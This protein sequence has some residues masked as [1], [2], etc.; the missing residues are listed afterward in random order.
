MIKFLANRRRSVF[1]SHTIAAQT[2]QR[3]QSPPLRQILAS[4]G[5]RG[6]RLSV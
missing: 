2:K 3:L 1:L 4:I 6:I 5:V